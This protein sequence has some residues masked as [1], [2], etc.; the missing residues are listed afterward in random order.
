MIN[1]ILEVFRSAGNWHFEA[2]KA[3]WIKYLESLD[4]EDLD[5]LVNIIQIID[6][7]R[8]DLCRLSGYINMARLGKL[9]NFESLGLNRNDPRLYDTTWEQY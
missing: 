7:K 9:P 1:E 5:T 8:V 4:K 2:S 6:T 3:L